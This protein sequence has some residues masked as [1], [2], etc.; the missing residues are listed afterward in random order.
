MSRYLYRAWDTIEKEMFEPCSLNNHDDF[1]AGFHSG[2]LQVSD[3]PY[4]QESR[5]ILMQSVDVRDDGN[6]LLYEQ[7]I[8]IVTHML[9]ENLPS[10]K[11][12][13]E[14]DKY[15]FAL[16][17]IGLVNSANQETLSPPFFGLSPYKSL[18]PFGLSLK[19]IGDAF[20][21]PELL[22]R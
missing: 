1:F 3:S 7:D 10:Y 14:W 5:Y 15:R 22:T 6:T 21:N 8:V 20:R 12:I 18:D 4:D 2:K 16:R 9:V 17:N 11:A 19:R 13:I